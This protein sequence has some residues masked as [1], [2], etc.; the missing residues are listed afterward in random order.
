MPPMSPEERRA[1]PRSSE[2]PRGARESARSAV[3]RPD[4]GFSTSVVDVDVRILRERE[5]DELRQLY[6]A[7]A[8]WH[9]RRFG[10]E[11]Q[12]RLA[13][14]DDRQLSLAVARARREMPR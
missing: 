5:L 9:E 3:A 8:R 11:R 7:C 10:G 1:V 2:P 12:G 14:P 6:A 4:S 13:L